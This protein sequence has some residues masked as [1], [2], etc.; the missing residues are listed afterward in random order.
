MILASYKLTPS[1]G[2]LSLDV[3]VSLTSNQR[4]DLE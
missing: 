4:V 3:R 2:K 1:Y